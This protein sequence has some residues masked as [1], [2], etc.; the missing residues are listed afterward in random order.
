MTTRLQLDKELDVENPVFIEGLAGI[1]HIGKTTVSYL[2][3]HLNAEKVGELYSHHFPPYTIVNDNKTVDLLKNDIYQ[4]QREDDRDM[5]IIEGNAQAST[6]EGHYEV[7]EK[8]MSLVDDVGSS[9]ILTIGGYGTGDVVEEP[10]VFGAV[11]TE[12]VKNEYTECGVEF[13]H[14]VGQIV[15]AS[16]LI[17]ALSREREIPG[18]CLLGETPGFLLSDPKATES[19]LQAIENILGLDIDYSDLDKKVEESQEVLKKLQN[20]QQKQSQDSGESQQDLG[21][22]G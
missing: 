9:E 12:K 20:L 22:I 4:V 2:V 6:P 15:G 10:D 8:I 16:G 1:G 13:D 7:A 14:D 5:V 17:L 3:H 19:V 11:T 18:I 21:Y